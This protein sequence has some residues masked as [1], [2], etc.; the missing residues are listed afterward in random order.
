MIK[1]HLQI[2]NLILMLVKIYLKKELDALSHTA[3]NFFH[4]A[5]SVFY[6]C[7]LVNT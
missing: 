6:Q 4:F 7:Q 1:S 2:L 3:T 5:L